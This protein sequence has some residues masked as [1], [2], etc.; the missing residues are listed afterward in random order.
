MCTTQWYKQF[1]LELTAF[2]VNNFEKVIFIMDYTFTNLIKDEFYKCIFF[3]S[4][5]IFKNL[6]FFDER[7]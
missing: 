2:S 1:N 4:G 3:R 7:S 6:H 5:E